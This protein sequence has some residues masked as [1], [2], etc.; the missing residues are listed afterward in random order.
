MSFEPG[1]EGVHRP[2]GGRK[3]RNRLH[4]LSID[5]VSLVKA[6]DNPSARVTLLKA[7]SDSDTDGE[8]A[9]DKTDNGDHMPDNDALQGASPSVIAYVEELEQAVIKAE[10][11]RDEALAQVDGAASSDDGAGEPQPT[12]DL[13]KV[14]KSADPALAAVIRKMQAD[15]QAA[16]ER[17]AQ[18]ETI[19]KQEAAA[20]ARMIL[21]HRVTEKMN[22]LGEAD[23]VTDVLQKAASSMDAETY[24]AIEQLLIK[25]NNQAHLGGM[26]TEIGTTGATAQADPLMQKA[27][28][29][30]KADPQLTEAQAIDRAMEL[31]P[32]L[33]HQSVAV[34]VGGGN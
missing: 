16:T 15:T 25:A 13:E 23:Q 12:D 28:E 1:L 3:A 27:E 9:V 6:G 22:H 26:F 8:G 20:R 2:R 11:E 30:R 5:F 7:R 33:Y 21:K 32:Q 18:A 24:A 14:L 17:A 34:P 10:Q 31:Y 4:N 19:A 29:I